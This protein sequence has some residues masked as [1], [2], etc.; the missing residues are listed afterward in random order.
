L[1]AA[2]MSAGFA[3][4]RTMS[5][6]K[7][8][9]ETPDLVDVEGVDYLARIKLIAEICHQFPQVFLAKGRSE[10]ERF[11]LE[12]IKWRWMA[13]PSDG[14]LWIVRVLAEF[15]FRIEDVVNLQELDDELNRMLDSAD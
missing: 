12:A 9:I 14:R 1:V 10:R 11:A 4:I 3:E 6:T 5:S 15:D 7:T 13:T 2:L 8:V